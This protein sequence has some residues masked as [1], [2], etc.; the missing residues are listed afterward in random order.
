MKD[1]DNFRLAHRTLLAMPPDM[2]DAA[3][4]L[5]TRLSALHKRACNIQLS[6]AVRRT[7]NPLPSRLRESRV[8]AHRDHVSIGGA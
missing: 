5:S 2:A 7:K 3:I 8:T 1:P 6:R 4:K